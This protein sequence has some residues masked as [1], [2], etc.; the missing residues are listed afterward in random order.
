MQLNKLTLFQRDY[1]N[2]HMKNNNLHLYMTLLAVS[3]MV[4]LMCACMMIVLVL[5]RLWRCSRTLVLKSLW[6]VI[7]ACSSGIEF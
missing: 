7:V 1:Y 2:L 3:S 6:S 4:E 5:L